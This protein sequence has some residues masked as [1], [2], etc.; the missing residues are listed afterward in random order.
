MLPI[1]IGTRKTYYL[2]KVMISNQK[3]KCIN[4]C[5]VQ[6]YDMVWLSTSPTKEL[7]SKWVPS[8]VDNP[9]IYL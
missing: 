4:G 7:R 3:H 9:E 6:Y 2:Q 5:Q 1:G 8:S